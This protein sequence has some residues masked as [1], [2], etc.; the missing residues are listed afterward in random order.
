MVMNSI[1]LFGKK[2]KYQFNPFDRNNIIGEGGMGKVFKGFD[3]VSNRP[4]AIKAIFTEL[5]VNPSV[6]YRSELEGELQFTH[7]NLIEMLDCCVTEEGRIHLV[8]VFVNGRS[9]PKY[10]SES[11]FSISDKSTIVCNHIQS[12][13]DALHFLHGKGIYHRDVKPDNIMIDRSNKAIL[14]DLGVAKA[15]DGKRKTNAGVV[16]GTPHYSAPEQIRGESNI[17]A[18]TDVYATG[19][20]LYELLTG[21][22][23]FDAG[24]QFGVMKM[25]IE[26]PLPYNP[27]IDPDLFNILKKATEKEQIQ[28]FQSAMDFSHALSEFL[29]PKS[30][31]QKLFLFNN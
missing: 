17:N 14:M 6:R 28:R 1:V 26:K 16:I 21:N 20:T 12:I 27:K 10:L 13:L 22:P 2:S 4:V 7:P 8:S 31:W 24:S 9:F 5:I 15:S 25:Q 29:K 19:I 11:A 23:P 3:M 18:T 30:F